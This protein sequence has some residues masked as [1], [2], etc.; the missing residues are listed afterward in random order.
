MSNTKPIATAMLTVY[1]G[2]Q[3]IGF[4]LRRGPVGVEAF[5]ASDD[6][7]GLFRNERDAASAIWKHARGQALDQG[8]VS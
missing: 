8:H 6:S 7:L 2:Q 4:V 3:A 5:T 1:D